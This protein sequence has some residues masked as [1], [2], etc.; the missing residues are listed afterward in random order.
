LC[1][2]TWRTVTIT[3]TH[4]WDDGTLDTWNVTTLQPKRWL[5]ANRLRPGAGLGLS[6]VLDLAEMGVPEGVVGEVVAIGPAP[7]ITEGPGRVVLT[8]VNHLNNFVFHLTLQNAQG[9]AETLGVTGH[10]KFY[11]QAQGWQS[12]VD[13]TVGDSLRGQDGQSLTVVDITRDPGVQR[14][15]NLTVES[16]HVY[17]VGDLTTLTHNNGCWLGAYDDVGG[18]HIF[19]KASYNT[20]PD[21]ESIVGRALSI[22]EAKINRLPGPGHRGPGSMTSLQQRLFDQLADDI[23]NGV[24][25]GGPTGAGTFRQHTRIAAKVLEHGGFSAEEAMRLAVQANRDLRTMGVRPIRIPGN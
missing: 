14:V 7:R 9:E 15:Y 8:T 21:F 11:D 13:L 4:Q 17:F 5:K 3:A 6:A 19:G 24:R 18:N 1:R 12:V 2:R 20:R 16:D 10:H 25:R 22:S 23:A